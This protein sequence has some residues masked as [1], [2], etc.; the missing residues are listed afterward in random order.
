MIFRKDR[1]DF[2]EYEEDHPHEHEPISR[3]GH[4]R[5]HGPRHDHEHD[6]EHN[7]QY[8]YEH[9]HHHGHRHHHERRHEHHYEHGYHHDYS[10]DQDNFFTNNERHHWWSRRHQDDY[11]PHSSFGNSSVIS[12]LIGLVGNLFGTKQEEHHHA[13][14]SL[15]N[16][17]FANYDMPEAFDRYGNPRQQPGM[18]YS[19]LGDKVYK[20]D[21]NGKPHEITGTPEASAY[22]Q[23]TFNLINDA[24]NGTYPS[25]EN[26]DPA[27]RF[28]YRP[29][30]GNDGNG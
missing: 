16:L 5:E 21:K 15:Y 1:H 27:A 10:Y 8:D 28:A 13:P 3:H 29:P 7:H 22:L 25:E 24:R 9:S 26:A 12:S 4:D 2:Q 6:H 14:D 30:Q 19:S 18:Q 11:S 23:D 17:G 20:Y